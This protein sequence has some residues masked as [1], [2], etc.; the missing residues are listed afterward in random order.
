MEFIP[1]PIISIGQVMD[2]RWP[3]DFWG[4]HPTMGGGNVLSQG[5]HAVDLLCH[6]NRS[7]PVSIFAEGGAFTHPG[8]PVIDNMV[9]TIRFANGRIA[10]LAQGDSGATP[11]VS[12]WSFQL[13]DGL[14]SVHLHDRL[15]AATFFDGDRTW[16][17]RDNEELGMLEENRAFIEAL[18][19]G[20]QP[21]TTWRDGLRATSVLL[22]AFEAIRSGVPHRFPSR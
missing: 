1:D 2:V 3:D 13:A 15:K 21:P 10:S 18:R 19:T 22:G 20:S 8:S 6:L 5:C 9:S 11:Y 4:Q 7:Q 12:K 17:E 14:K 16:T